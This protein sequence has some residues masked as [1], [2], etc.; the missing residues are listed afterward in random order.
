M[1]EVTDVQLDGLTCPSERHLMAPFS[2]FWW[3]FTQIPQPVPFHPGTPSSIPARPVGSRPC[4]NPGFW[5]WSPTSPSQRSP[6]P[7]GPTN[8]TPRA[9]QS[10]MFPKVSSRWPLLLSQGSVPDSAWVGDLNPPGWGWGLG[11]GVREISAGLAGT[12]Q[13]CSRKQDRDRKCVWV[14]ETVAGD[15]ATKEARKILAGAGRPR[16]QSDEVHFSVKAKPGN[17]GETI[18]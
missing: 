11:F 18:Q 14:G 1:F 8:L 3:I 13:G 9:A 17:Q 2:P 7:S 4:P 12:G 16:L 5:S 15:E 10:P 6:A